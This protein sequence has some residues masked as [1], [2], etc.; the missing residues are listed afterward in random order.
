MFV[1]S[2]KTAD[3][4]AKIGYVVNAISLCQQSLTLENTCTAKHQ[5]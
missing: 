3:H 1:T 5:D 4:Y 2:L